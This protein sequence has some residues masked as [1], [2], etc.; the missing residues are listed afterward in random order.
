MD[1]VALR[2]QAEA[3][4]V[5]RTEFRERPENKKTYRRH[6]ALA[7]VIAVYYTGYFSVGTPPLYLERVPARQVYIQ[8]EEIDM[9]V[10][11]TGAT[12]F[13]G[14]A[15]VRELQSAGHEVLG[16]ARSAAAADT[17]TQLGVKPY[18]GELSD[19]EGLS[20]A[21]RAADGVIHLAFIHDFSAHAAAAE[22]DRQAVETMTD[23]LAGS[24]KPFVL[25]S[26]TALLA[27]GRI[28][29]EADAPGSTINFRAASEAI[30]LE[31]AS[32]GVRSS[33]V[34]L[35]PSVHGAGD[36]GFVPALI[37]IARRAGVSA[38]IGDGANRWPSVHRLDAAR[39]FRLAL[40]NAAPGTRVHGIAEGGIAMRAIA[41][42]I[43]AGLD[44]PVRSIPADEAPAHFD[45]MARFV[46][47]DNPTSSARTRETFGWV[48]REKDLLTD[49][50]ES[51]YFS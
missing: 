30:T 28:G 32:R 44:L 50:R 46:A 13:I 19:T 23:A 43:G 11:V 29:T 26:G 47:I 45:W 7:R 20:A 8:I 49:M 21:A 51:G 15:V 31:A 38:Y 18:K 9:H 10:F 5:H 40:E 48:P 6:I 36:H 16:L 37:G 33:I 12:G 35:P 39:L 42:T 17:L 22:T 34:R 24:G 41:E 4:P 3:V 25:T 27:P 2:L 1:Q 14:T